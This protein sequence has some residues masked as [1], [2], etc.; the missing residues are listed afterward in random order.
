M[1]FNDEIVTYPAERASGKIV[2]NCE[3]ARLR[4]DIFGG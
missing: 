3:F 2:V 1:F 4:P